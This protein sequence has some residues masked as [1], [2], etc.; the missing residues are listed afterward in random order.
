MSTVQAF[1][2]GFMT[3]W[4]PHLLLLAWMLRRQEDMGDFNNN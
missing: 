4:T 1:L 3:A 2:L